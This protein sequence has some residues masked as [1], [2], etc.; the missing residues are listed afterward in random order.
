MR[1]ETCLSNEQTGDGRCSYPGISLPIRF[2]QVITA[3][4]FFPPFLPFLPPSFPSSLLPSFSLFF[5]LSLFSLVQ[6]L[7]EIITLLHLLENVKMM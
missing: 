6:S 5:F 3:F 1:L 7:R 4:L 2:Q